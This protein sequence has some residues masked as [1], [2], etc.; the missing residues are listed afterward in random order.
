M[1]PPP[2]V[3]SCTAPP[4]TDVWRLVRRQ[5]RSRH[6]MT[7]GTH[8]F[9]AYF[10]AMLLAV[11]AAGPLAAA[12]RTLPRSP[13]GPGGRD[14]GAGL[15]GLPHGFLGAVLTAAF[16]VLLL[17][18]ARTATW[19]GPLSLSAADATWL[20]PLPV[21]RAPWLRARACLALA[22]STAVGTLLGLSVAG[23]TFTLLRYPL[24]HG[25]S[26]HLV[27]L[28]SATGALLGMLTVAVGIA[29][30]RWR[31]LAE[32]AV[33]VTPTLTLALALLVGCSWWLPV[34]GNVVAWTGPWGWAA[35]P[36]VHATGESSTGWAA[37]LALLAAAT[38]TCA[39]VA[40]RAA[41]TVPA[42]RLRR[43]AAVSGGVQAAL[44]V[45]ETRDAA[46]RIRSARLAGGAALRLPPPRTAWL[47]IPWRDC[48]ALLRRP[49]G[50][51]A[52]A[53][54]AVA[55]V[56]LGLLEP[57]TA[58]API[59]SLAAAGAG[60][61][62][63]A[64]LVEPARLDADDPRRCTPL[65][66]PF[67][68]LAYW[69]AVVP[70]VVL[71]LVGT[72]TALVM[73]AATNSPPIAG[74][75]GVLALAPL[76]VGAALAG[77]YR[78]RAPMWLAVTGGDLGGL[79]PPGVP[80]LLLWYVAAPLVGIGGTVYALRSQHAPVIDVLLLVTAG[81]ALSWWVGQRARAVGRLAR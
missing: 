13:A 73:S 64:R 72:P 7:L 59:V 20:L 29:A 81:V 50:S 53:L 33:R 49:A 35:L 67:S 65:R 8:G 17:T 16:V 42:R 12:M 31:A 19:C 57:S 66:Q 28:C 76:L 10:M 62:A 5:R 11:Y 46:V 78:G 47:V 56:V 15:T 43:S 1:M 41:G 80:L 40:W 27:G 39:G 68:R 14:F 22:V 63:A 25:S 9:T 23:A 36:L 70:T 61:L 2:D 48:L 54:L 69:H 75:L 71:V 26:A 79:G 55:A 21:D 44:L 3:G 74:L 38:V 52:A 18:A 58:S 30:Q 32:G 60:Y 6:R 51:A 45:G 37:A 24:T 4:A 77:A 34:P